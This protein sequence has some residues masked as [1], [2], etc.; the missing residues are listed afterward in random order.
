[1]EPFEFYLKKELVKR[2]SPNKFRARFL[3]KDVKDRL[4]FIKQVDIVQFPKI[5]LEM[6]YDIIRDYCDAIL[7]IDGY[8]S[9]SHEASISYLLKKGFDFI[10]ISRLDSFRYKRNGSKYYGEPI[11]VEDAKSLSELYLKIES[12]LNNILKDKL[13]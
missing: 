13:K 6:L 1:M 12:R 11:F 2:I 3:L 10:T 5:Y 8:K 4:N 7:F 9:F